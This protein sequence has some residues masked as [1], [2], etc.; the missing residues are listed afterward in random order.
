MSRNVLGNRLLLVVL[1]TGTLLG[2]E[3][4][5]ADNSND[6]F[7]YGRVTSESG[8]EYSGFLRWGTE[9]AFWDDLFHSSKRELPYAEYVDDER[10]SRRQ[11]ERRVSIFKK[12][13]TIKG[14]WSGSRMFI[15]RFGDI[16]EIQPRGDN[17]AD[18]KMKNGE[19]YR[20]EG[21]AN[22]VSDPIHV[23][24]KSLGDIDLRWNK[25][26]SIEFMPAPRGEDPGAWRLLG[27]VETDAGVFEGF[28]QWDKEECLSTDKLDGDTE[29]GDISIPMGQIRS[30]ER[31]GR[32]SSLI[33]LKDGRKLRLR[34][35][36][37]VNSDNRGIM[38]EDPRF[39]RVTINWNAFDHLT[40]SEARGSG[41]GYQDFKPAGRLAG[42][43][44]NE[45]G[46]QYRGKIVI[47]LDEAEGWEILNGSYRDVDYDIPLQ[48]V[49]VIE[50]RGLAGSKV[51]LRTGETITLEEGQDV[52]DRN[53]G[54][55][56]F[57]DDEDDPVYIPWDEV[58]EVRL[59]H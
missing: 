24:D 44:T 35:S 33:E 25:I 51:T 43:V 14:D 16:A 47:D 27:K 58:K 36:N 29:D 8:T 21:V 37:D 30:I 13:I 11:E 4:A 52:S 17:E 5:R 55:L 48:L 22:D 53:D 39:G 15:S 3:H 34:G 54:V 45:D 59:S 49:E 56:V 32:G 50:P 6:G 20:V 42:T 40:F 7:I 12:I 1:I 26:E 46:E 23:K 38:V 28:I 19:V 41:R 31:R 18:V 57:A 10:R 9:E 2:A